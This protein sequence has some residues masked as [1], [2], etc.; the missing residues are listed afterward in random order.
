MLPVLLT[1]VRSRFI[2]CQESAE[3]RREPTHNLSMECGRPRGHGR[4]PEPAFVPH[5][6]RLGLEWCAPAGWVCQPTV[7]PGR[8][9][10]SVRAAFFLAFCQ[11]LNHDAEEHPMPA[12]DAGFTY[13]N[14]AHR[15]TMVTPSGRAF[16]TLAGG[17][18]R[19]ELRYGSAAGRGCRPV[20]F[21]CAAHAVVLRI[22]DR[23]H[24]GHH[25]CV[26]H[27]GTLLAVEPAAR[28]HPAAGQSARGVVAAAKAGQV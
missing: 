23:H 11:V 7:F 5:G 9:G 19:H 2:G 10:K 3:V 24:G 14:T 21:L 16:A 17:G 20:P 25:G 6:C 4:V 15:A 26:P 27:S 13:V 18:W 8:H 1:L 22:R 28:V 12:S